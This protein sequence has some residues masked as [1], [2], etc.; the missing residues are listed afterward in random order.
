MNYC[1]CCNKQITAKVL[2]HEK[3]LK[4]LFGTLK[5]PDI[6]FSKPELISEIS[7][8]SGKMSISGAQI[9]ASV[10]YNKKNNSID[11]VEAGSTHILKPD[12]TEYPQL[13]ENE[14]LCMNLAEAAGINIPPHGLFYLSDNSLC[15]IIKRFD[16]DDKGKKIHVEDMAQI[17]GLSPES[18]Y[19]SSLEKVG[20]AI[21]K[22]SKRPYLDLIYF[23]ERV[24]FCF[25]IGNGD[26]HL[27][28]W[29]FISDSSGN[30][31]LA[32]CY[33]LVCS[34][35]YLPGEEQSAL[36]INGKRNKLAIADFISLA[37]YLRIDQKACNNVFKKMRNLED[38]FTDII[39]NSSYFEKRNEFLEILQSNFKKLS[40]LLSQEII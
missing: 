3:C 1:F 6:S 33:D 20:N 9:K 39:K 32:P 22:F 29:S 5:V 26:M 40:D 15:Y 11:V 13:P 10:I 27:K 36:M 8:K 35:L 24:I 38:I 12:P 17:L 19:D 37:K 7:S 4:K 34:K 28:N 30:Y 31:M 18:K 23:F 25:L 16:R 21:I 2:Y 14:N